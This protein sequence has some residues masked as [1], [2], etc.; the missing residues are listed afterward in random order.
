MCFPDAMQLHELQMSI[1]VTHFTG[2]IKKKS[3]RNTINVR[4]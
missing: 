3:N 1:W 4:Q 2:A